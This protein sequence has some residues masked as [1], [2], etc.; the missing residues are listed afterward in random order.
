MMNSV[1]DAYGGS[2]MGVIL[3]GMG[4]NG[5]VGLTNL[6]A[7]KG[8]IIAQNEESCVVYGMPR[9]AIEAGVADHIVPIETVADEMM[10]YF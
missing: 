6:R 10:T 3:T 8:V 7:K 5:V 9:A 1:V 2:T 4:N